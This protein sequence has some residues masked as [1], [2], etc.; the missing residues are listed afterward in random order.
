MNDKKSQGLSYKK[1]PLCFGKNIDQKCLEDDCAWFV[2]SDDMAFGHCA[3]L[4]IA[5]SL[6][7]LYNK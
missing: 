2:Y 7:A 4:D 5:A 3:V 6:T 1:C